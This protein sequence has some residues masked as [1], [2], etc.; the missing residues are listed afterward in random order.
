MKHIYFLPDPP[1]AFSPPAIVQSSV[2]NLSLVVDIQ[3]NATPRS[4]YLSIVAASKLLSTCT[5]LSTRISGLM[6]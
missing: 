2:A 1:M 6:M 4:F 3:S 5:A